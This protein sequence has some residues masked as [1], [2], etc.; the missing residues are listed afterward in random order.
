ME[1]PL[2]MIKMIKDMVPILIDGV[3]PGPYE[4]TEDGQIWSNYKKDFL[5]PSFDKDGYLKIKLSGGDRQHKKYFRIGNL[6]ALMYIGSPKNLKDPTINHIDGNILNNHYSNLEWVERG[7]NSSIRLNKGEGSNNHQAKLN[8]QQVIEI[9]ELLINTN[10]T[11]DQI[12]NKYDIKKTTLSSIKNQKSWKKITNQYDFS[13]RQVVRNE[14][15]QFESINTK[16]V[17][18]ELNSN[19]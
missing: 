12:C 13:C 9:C 8:E 4:I 14:K 18:G 7:Y 6:V 3:K 10:L 2:F 16:L 5:C 15:G 19:E 17:Y 1:A 11:Y